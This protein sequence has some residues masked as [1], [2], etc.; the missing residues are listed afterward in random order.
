MPETEIKSVFYHV[1]ELR[2]L[3]PC[4]SVAERMKRILHMSQVSTWLQ[5]AQWPDWVQQQ[6]A[7]QTRH[8]CVVCEICDD[9]AQ[10]EYRLDDERRTEQ[11]SHSYHNEGDLCIPHN[12]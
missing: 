1:T 8:L 11:S 12:M 2:I 7:L 6:R 9:R 4:D 5:N 3:K 10:A